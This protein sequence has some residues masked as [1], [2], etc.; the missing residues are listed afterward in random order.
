MFAQ[1]TDLLHNLTEKE[2]DGLS[3]S[4]PTIQMTL[5]PGKS[6]RESLPH[7]SFPSLRT[8]FTRCV[9]GSEVLFQSIGCLES[10]Q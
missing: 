4:V 6:L 7:S 8:D 3:V 5:N 1:N 9:S 10:D 2:I